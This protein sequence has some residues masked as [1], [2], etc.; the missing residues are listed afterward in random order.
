ML[1]SDRDIAH[2][3]HRDGLPHLMRL[4]SRESACVMRSAGAFGHSPRAGRPATTGKCGSIVALAR[5][6]PSRHG[7]DHRRSNGR[8]DAGPIGRA[9]SENVAERK[10]P[11]RHAAPRRPHDRPGR[12]RRADF[13]HP[14]MGGN[15][16]IA[17]IPPRRGGQLTSTQSV[18]HGRSRFHLI[19]KRIWLG[20]C[21]RLH[22]G[23]GSPCPKP[24]KSLRFW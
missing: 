19:V 12:P 11:C 10:T 6:G 15:A 13:R 1:G 21:V 23:G 5:L 16:Q 20:P 9:R 8:R 2:N 4:G 22:G 14:T 3:P 24:G 17:A 7:L 18:L